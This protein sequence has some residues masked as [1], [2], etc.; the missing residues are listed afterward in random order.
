[1]AQDFTLHFQERGSGPPLLLIHGFPFSS[2]M[3]NRQLDAL[4]GQC[5]LLAPDLPGFGDSPLLDGTYS[6]ERYA[7]DCITVLDA[8]DILEP[9]AIGGLSMGGYIALA[10]ARLFPER[11]RALLLLSTRAGADSAEGQANRGKTI[12]AVKEQGASAVTEAMYPK[13]LAPETY[14]ANPAAAAEL[15][16]IMRAASPEG[17]IAALGAMRDRPDSTSLLTQIDVP[18]LIVHGKQDAIIPSSE[19]EAM[20]KAI[21]NSQLHLI[22]HAGHLPNLEQPH[23]FNRVIANFLDAITNNG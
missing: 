12:A 21:R 17:V 11:L 18:T 3:W 5:R 23:E 8:L 20:A 6:V 14:T 7:E 10:I 13:L 1:M 16:E 4:S 9:V 15:Q 2:Q 19:A 22:D